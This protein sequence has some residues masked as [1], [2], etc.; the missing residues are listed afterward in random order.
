MLTLL[1]N[2]I[3]V[4]LVFWFTMIA[5][6]VETFALIVKGIIIFAAMCVLHL[7]DFIKNMFLDI[8]CN[9]PHATI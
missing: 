9:R 2:I 1:M 5:D 7:I 3:S 6:V 8:L 4:V